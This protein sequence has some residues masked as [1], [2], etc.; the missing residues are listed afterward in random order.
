MRLTYRPCSTKRGVVIGLGPSAPLPTR[1]VLGQNWA[2]SIRDVWPKRQSQCLFVHGPICPSPPKL[3]WGAKPSNLFSGRKL[4]TEIPHPISPHHPGS[5]W[6]TPGYGQN[7]CY[8]PF[9]TVFHLD[10]ELCN[11]DQKCKNLVGP[12]HIVGL[13]LLP[14]HVFLCGAFAH[15]FSTHRA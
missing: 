10:D 11:S 4:S 12:G 5:P 14:H 2:P 7:G 8:G 3:P 6:L 15:H 1:F 13:C 9:C